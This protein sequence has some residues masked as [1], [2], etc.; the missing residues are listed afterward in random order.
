MPYV[1]VWVDGPEFD[2]EQRKALRGLIKTAIEIA[3][4]NWPSEDAVLLS[5]AAE[6]VRRALLD[7]AAD[8]HKGPSLFPI[9]EKYRQWRAALRA[10]T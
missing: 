1:E 6:Q 5:Q 10:A 4:R 3:D 2:P 7:V 8:P 9:D